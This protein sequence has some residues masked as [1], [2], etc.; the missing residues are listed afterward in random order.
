MKTVTDQIIL[1]ALAKRRPYA[2]LGPIFIEEADKQGRHLPDFW[3]C[4][5]FFFLTIL[6]LYLLR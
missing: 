2:K 5:H 3:P 6:L 4:F 1:L